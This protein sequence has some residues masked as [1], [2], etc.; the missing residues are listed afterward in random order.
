MCIS[1]QSDGLPALV[2][3]KKGLVA[4]ARQ[5]MKFIV[6]TPAFKGVSLHRPAQPMKLKSTI[7]HDQEDGFGLDNGGGLQSDTSADGAEFEFD[8]GM[9]LFCLFKVHK[10]TICPTYFPRLIYVNSLHQLLA[11][12]SFVFKKLAHLVLGRNN[13]QCACL[14]FF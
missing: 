8:A 10:C 6:V 4:L 13:L 7:L 11:C 2:T 14:L 12:F 3:L 5:W 9:S 1:F